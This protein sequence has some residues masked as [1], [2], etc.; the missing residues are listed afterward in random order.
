MKEKTCIRC[1]SK[2]VSDESERHE[3]VLK[4]IVCSMYYIRT[5]KSDIDRVNTLQNWERQ[6]FLMRKVQNRRDFHF[7]PYESK[8]GQL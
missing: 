8:P 6:M 7:S 3:S 1:R 5:M 2:D 4:C